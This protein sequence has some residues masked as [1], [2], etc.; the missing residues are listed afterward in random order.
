MHNP[1]V[2][3]FALVGV[4]LLAM[5]PT[6]ADTP[7]KHPAYLHALSDLRDSRAHLQQQGTGNATGDLAEAHAIEHIDNAINEIKQAAIMDGK[8]IQDHM[9]VDAHLDRPGRL[10]TALDLLNKAKNDV[11]GEE[12]Q[13]DTKGLQM[14]VLKHI[15]EA[16]LSVQHA[17]EIVLG[18]K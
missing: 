12:D 8:N 3:A 11:S 7:G 1:L 15:D 9:P 17:I 10:H 5:S 13:P 16:R 18:H 2:K 14:R 6:W 4:A